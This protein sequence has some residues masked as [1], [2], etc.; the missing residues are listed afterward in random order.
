MACLAPPDAVVAE[1]GGSLRLFGGLP[2]LVAR[3]AARRA[4][5][6]YATRSASR[7]RR[8]R[9][10]CSR[11]PAS[12]SPSTTRAQLP[13]AAGAACRSRCS[14]STTPR[15]HTLRGRR[16]DVRRRPRTAARRARAA[17]RRRDRR[18]HRSL[19]S[20]S[21]PIRAPSFVPPPRYAGTPRP[22][23][24]GRTTSRRSRSACTA[25]CTSS[26]T[27]SPPA[28]SASCA[29]RSSL[30]SRALL[31]PA[32]AARRPQC[33][34][35]SARRRACRRISSACC[36]SGLRASRCRR[37]SKRSRLRSDETAPLAGR[38]L[39]L[40]P[41]DD[42]DRVEV[43]LVDRLRARLG[44][45]ALIRLAPHAE[46]RPELRR[47]P[48]RKPRSA[49]D[50]G[51]A[52]PPLARFAAAAPVWLLSEP[53]PLALDHG[54]AAVGVARRSRAH[55]V[56]MVGRR[57]RAPRLFRR[58]YADGDTVGSTA[59][60]AT[61]STTASGSCTGC[62]PDTLSRMEPEPH[63]PLP[64]LRCPLCGQANACA[65]AATGSFDTPCWC[66][67][68]DIDP[69]AVAALDGKRDACLCPACAQAARTREP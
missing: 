18:A 68:V 42:A 14:I 6:G 51:H 67:T 37:R 17:L 25:S 64:N 60:T 66:T 32:R 5:M 1:I 9:P 29:C 39:G 44:E 10:C 34:S 65:P 61:A 49:R 27:G 43:P 12:R 53:Q 2:R 30:A 28:D 13:H 3:L 33:R 26:R 52:A 31:A 57:R 16:H 58:G 56:R 23:G 8:A 47:R 55:R 22:A 19:R 21:L 4:A 15:A 46:H 63:A 24:A 36:A 11:A 20:A 54:I 45:D 7:P 50:P 41:G 40:L 35:R 38:N 62:S 59:T 69:R 48:A